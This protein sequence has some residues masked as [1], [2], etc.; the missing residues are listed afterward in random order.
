[1]STDQDTYSYDH[2]SHER[3]AFLATHLPNATTRA[4]AGDASFRRYFRINEHPYLLMDAPPPEDVRPFVQVAKLLAP[5]VNVPCIIAQDV[6]NGFLLLQDFGKVEFAQVIKTPQKEHWYQ[7][8]LSVLADLQKIV[9]TG[10]PCYGDKYQLE[11]DLF[12]EWFLSYI[13][14]AIDEP[15]WQSLK[16]EL[17]QKI[18][19]QPKVLVHRDYHSRNLMIDGDKIGVIDFQD[20]QVGAYTYDLVSLIRDAYI[21]ESEEWVFVKIQEFYDL[22]NPKVSLQEFIAQTY[23][24]GIQRNLKVLGIFVRLSKRDG[25]DKYMADIPKVMRDLLAQVTW[26]Y[27]QGHGQIYG[28]FLKFLQGILP[29]YKDKFGVSYE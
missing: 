14:A 4:L 15:L 9:P 12:A 13:G 21:E 25:K 5:H 17:V 26:L 24:M 7:K 2:R 6:D 8:A 29:Q 18:N 22:L 1:M 20:A 11:M 28:D 3:H 16:D 10:I 19:E 27:A 23:V